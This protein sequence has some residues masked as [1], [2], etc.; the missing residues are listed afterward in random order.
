MSFILKS[1]T[2]QV[3]NAGYHPPVVESSEASSA[4]DVLGNGP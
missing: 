1:I 3:S 4:N 2:D